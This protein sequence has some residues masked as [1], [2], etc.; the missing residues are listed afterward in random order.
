MFKDEIRRAGG[1][2]VEGRDGIP[3]SW[4]GRPVDVARP[5]EEDKQAEYNRL[6]FTR[7]TPREVD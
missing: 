7:S 4:D 6:H 2:I 5:T 3:R 1:L